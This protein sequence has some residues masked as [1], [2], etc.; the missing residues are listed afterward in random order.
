MFKSNLKTISILAIVVISVFS[1]SFLN[2]L[3]FGQITGT[4]SYA[5]CVNAS[6]DDCLVFVSEG[7]CT[8]MQVSGNFSFAACVQE[9]AGSDCIQDGYPQS[10]CGGGTAW[11]CNHSYPFG[12]CTFEACHCGTSGGTNAEP[13]SSYGS[14]SE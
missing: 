14:C 12:D 8:A 7:Y 13:H 4:M 11:D 6:C 10:P 9:Q 5:V 1:S 3:V 2:S